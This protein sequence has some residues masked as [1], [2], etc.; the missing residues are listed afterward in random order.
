M[1]Y[2]DLFIDGSHEGPELLPLHVLP[3]TP[4]GDPFGEFPIVRILRHMAE[5]SD[6]RFHG[7]PVRLREDE[8]FHGPLG[9]A[10]EILKK[11]YGVLQN[12]EILAPREDVCPR[13]GL[14]KRAR[15][16]IRR[17]ETPVDPG[18]MRLREELLGQDLK[19][20]GLDVRLDAARYIRGKDVLQHDPFPRPDRS[21]RKRRDDGVGLCFEH[22][23][24]VFFLTTALT[25]SISLRAA[26]LNDSSIPVRSTI[27]RYIVSAWSNRPIFSY[28]CP[29][30]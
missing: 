1:L 23:Y 3:S 7:H 15:E 6:H 17:G 22:A 30:M 21:F 20:V 27:C 19:S 12:D 11:M 14:E 10:E 16:A 18:T 13:E 24:P 2:D 5:L 26:A 25:R 8:V 28:D 29:D 4:S 9:A